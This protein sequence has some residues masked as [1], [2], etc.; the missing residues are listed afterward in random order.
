[1]GTDERSRLRSVKSQTRLIEQEIKVKKTRIVGEKDNHALPIASYEFTEKDFDFFLIKFVL[2]CH[3]FDTEELGPLGWSSFTA[4]IVS[5]AEFQSIIKKSF[6]LKF[7]ALELG[8][9]VN[10][11]YPIGK[12][13]DVMNCRI[14]IDIFLQNKLLTGQFKGDKRENKLLA[15]YIAQLKSSYLS[16][17]KTSEEF[18]D[19][20]NAVQ[21]R[22]W[23]L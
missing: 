20:A 18:L 2:K 15:E 14:F 19:S 23:R 9:L 7:T 4:E 6:H 3:T 21:L 5:L 1:V 16:K 13:M 17:A 22:P 12:S 10:Y 8:A 11:C